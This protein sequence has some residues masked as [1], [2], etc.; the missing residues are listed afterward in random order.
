MKDKSRKYTINKC[1]SSLAG[2]RKSCDLGRRL[3]V[4]LRLMT[5]ETATKTW[6]SFQA[7]SYIRP[8]IANR[9]AIIRQ[10]SKAA[11]KFI[12]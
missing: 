5:G 6:R 8:S 4:G 9:L 12:S 1:L 10:S 2:R 3:H 11:S 7:T